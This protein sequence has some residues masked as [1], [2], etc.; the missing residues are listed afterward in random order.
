MRK[1]A[2][3]ATA[4]AVTMAF[5]SVSSASALSWSP[6]STKTTIK[7]G[8]DLQ[9]VS[10]TGIV[11]AE[12]SNPTAPVLSGTATGASML[13]TNQT[14]N[15]LGG[16]GG[17]SFPETVEV[18]RF[19][20]WSEVATSTSAVTLKGTGLGETGAI[21]TITFPH[22]RECNLVVRGTVSSTGGVW[23]NTKHTLT[24]NNS[25]PVEVLS[26][27][28]MCSEYIGKKVWLKGT[29]IHDSNVVINP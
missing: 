4:V 20:T 13:L 24:L 27:S 6:Q 26:H 12:C 29:L 21:M 2:L 5:A 7:G 19:G 11:T 14:L 18:A 8:S 25:F 16:I 28:V 9:L 23:S 1:I 15:C 17:K 3:V 22:F 10:E